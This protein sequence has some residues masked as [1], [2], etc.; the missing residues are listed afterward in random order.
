M[1]KGVV[2]PFD[3]CIQFCV[4]V[5]LID[6]TTLLYVHVN[7]NNFLFIFRATGGGALGGRVDD[8]DDARLT[9]VI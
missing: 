6:G 2:D 9:P 4:V 8:D 3:I 1:A 7:I 5:Q